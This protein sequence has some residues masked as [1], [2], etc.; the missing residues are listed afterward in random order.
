MKTQTPRQYLKDAAIWSAGINLVL[1]LLAGWL[2][3]RKTPFIPLEGQTSLRGD[4]TVMVFLIVFFSL[5]LAVP[6]IKKA[7]KEGK[8][9]PYKNAKAFPGAVRWLLG[10][11]LPLA[12][13][14]AF[15]CVFLFVPVTMWKLSW[16]HVDGLALWPFLAF[17]SIMAALTAGTV[18]PLI[19]WLVIKNESAAG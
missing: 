10:K 6:G 9:L 19:D 8:L 13:L 12:T 5:L 15:L 3:Y 17:K 18:V 7:I 2:I 16:L 11:G 4:T 14:V 1:N